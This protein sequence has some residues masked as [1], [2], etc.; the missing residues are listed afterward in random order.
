MTLRIKRAPLGTGEFGNW[1][2]PRRCLR[3]MSV[4]CNT[5]CTEN[6]VLLPLSAHVVST[7]LGET[8]RYWCRKYSERGFYEIIGDGGSESNKTASSDRRRDSN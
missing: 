3:T 4:T 6:G 5:V 1:A 7:S 2:R 8:I